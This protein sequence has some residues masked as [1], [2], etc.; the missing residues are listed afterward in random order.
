MIISHRHRYIFI[1]TRKTA[2]TSI[3]IALSVNCGDDDVV[4]PVVSA[5]EAA[6]QAAGGC[7]PRNCCIPWSR[8]KPRDWLRGIVRRERPEFTNHSG[9]S[10]V[11]QH[12]PPHVWN[13]YFKFCFERNPFDKLISMYYW[14]HPTEPRPSIEEFVHSPRLVNASDYDRYTIK[15]RIA[16]DRVFRF[17]E[18][19]QSMSELQQILGLD[20]L[21]PLPRAKGNTRQDRRSYREVL[22]PAERRRIEA[23]FARELSAFGYEW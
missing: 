19:A 12:V 9:A 8:W 14:K 11:R 3:E 16:V 21:F 18:L 6:R 15:G 20:G 13:N 23:V 17:E 22:G 2:G 4:T 1:K 7:S 10:F 5:D